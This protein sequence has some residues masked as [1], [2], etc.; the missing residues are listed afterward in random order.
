MCWLYKKIY[1]IFF[2]FTVIFAFLQYSCAVKE[3]TVYE[4]DGMLYGT[5]DGLFKEKWNDYYLRGLSYSQG[6]FWQDASSDF[7]QAIAQRDKDQR[8]ARTY[9]MHFIDYFPKRELGIACY[10]LGNH[11]EA[12]QSL[13][14][15]LSDFKTARAVF[16]LNKARQKLLK[17]TGLDTMP[18]TLAVVTPTRDYVTSSLSMNVS[19]SAHDDFYVSKILVNGNPT[20]LELSQKDVTFHKEIILHDGKNLITVQAEDLT[21]KKSPPVKFEVTVDRNGPLVFLEARPDGNNTIHISGAVFDS[22]A[23]SKVTINNNNLPIGYKQ[24]EKINYYVRSDTLSGGNKIQFVAVDRAGN[25][26]TG[27]IHVVSSTSSCPPSKLPLIAYSGEAL[28]VMKIPSGQTERNFTAYHS[29]TSHPSQ[30]YIQ[31]KGCEDG[32]TVLSDTLFLEGFVYTPAGIKDIR[33]NGQSLLQSDMNKSFKAFL[34]ELGKSTRKTLSFS[35]LIQLH[36]K[37]N[38]VS[39]ELIDHKGLTITKAVSVIR[40]IPAIRQV[41]SRLTV[42]IY[43]FRES[44]QNTEPLADYIES[45]LTKCFVQQKRFN[46]LERKQ[47]EQLLTE[48]Q[49]SQESI[50]DQQTAIRLGRLMASETVLLGDIFTTEQSVEIIARMVDTET[51]LILA[52]KDVYWEGENLRGLRDAIGGL[53]L[54]F[55]QHFPL[56]EGTIISKKLRSI[57]IDL[58]SSHSLC[59]GMK[60]LA[61][62]ENDPLIHPVTKKILGRK[63]EVLGLVTATEVN[64]EF[65]KGK[66]LEKF[67]ERDL[68]INDKVITK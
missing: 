15:S 22:S 34:R 50:F 55:K 66:I 54:K 61:F 5:V 8:R 7:K 48:Q 29:Q 52:E 33:V 51:S 27:F 4:K 12:I 24:F 57:T 32:Q 49:L 11:E 64:K 9:G 62:R 30:P 35:K 42:S 43:P 65:A 59:T 60:L 46:V 19:G 3:S 39:V 25:H 38:T 16:Y 56:C 47:L 2:V 40:K 41:G 17:K 1:S 36:E 45:F 18:P 53:A 20:S 14:A 23:L 67:T 28:P 13:E 68:K 63:T 6:G 26:T 37:A 31:L 10:H 21:E 44:K 58:G